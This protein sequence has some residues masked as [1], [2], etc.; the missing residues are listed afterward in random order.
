MK[1]LIVIGLQ[2]F[3]GACASTTMNLASSLRAMRGI[4]KW[5]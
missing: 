5:V 4:S 1:N 2:N 3:M